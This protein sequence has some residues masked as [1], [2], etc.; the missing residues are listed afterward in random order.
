[1]ARTFVESA[2]PVLSFDA[3]VEEDWDVASAAMACETAEAGCADEIT[4][5]SAESGCFDYEAGVVVA[6][7]AAPAD[8]VV[9]ATPLDRPVRRRPRGTGRR[10]RR[11]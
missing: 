8:T 10:R 3:S 5:C 9:W 7:T 6:L 1:M 2:D 11:T 4:V